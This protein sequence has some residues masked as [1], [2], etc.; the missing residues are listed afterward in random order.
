MRRGG[1]GTL[2]GL[3]RLHELNKVG[4]SQDHG[5]RLQHENGLLSPALSSSGGEG[6]RRVHAVYE[7]CGR[8][9]MGQR[10]RKV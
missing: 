3:N 4:R 9:G 5:R 8:R 1:R 10:V 7:S 2:H 6:E